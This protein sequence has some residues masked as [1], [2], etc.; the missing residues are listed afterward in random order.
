MAMHGDSR[1]WFY[2]QLLDALCLPIRALARLRI[3]LITY[4]GRFRAAL[5]SATS[6]GLGLREVD[7]HGSVL[8]ASPSLATFASDIWGR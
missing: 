3:Q 8:R 6:H 7:S 2:H 4:G 1:L 5:S